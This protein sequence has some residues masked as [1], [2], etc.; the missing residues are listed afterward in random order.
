MKKRQ[1]K[2]IWKSHRMWNLPIHLQLKASKRWDKKHLWAHDLQPKDKYLSCDG[3]VEELISKEWITYEYCLTGTDGRCHYTNQCADP[4]PKELQHIPV[5]E[6]LSDEQLS[7][8][9]GPLE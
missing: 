4:L 8:I 2:K 7:T 1:L 3:I 9:W 6:K 5:G